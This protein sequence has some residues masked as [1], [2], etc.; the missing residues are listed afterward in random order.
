MTLNYAE[1]VYRKTFFKIKNKIIFVLVFHSKIH[2]NPTV[3]LIMF[4]KRKQ[5]FMQS[6]FL[7]TFRNSNYI[8]LV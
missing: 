1:K 2:K 3:K 6:M 5:F 7:R 4:E 8:Y